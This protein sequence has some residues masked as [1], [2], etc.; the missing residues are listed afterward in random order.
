MWYSKSTVGFGSRW[1][2]EI[3]ISSIKRMFGEGVM[4]LKWSN[5]GCFLIRQN[6]CK[7]LGCHVD[8]ACK[9]AKIQKNI[10][11]ESGRWD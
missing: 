4:A 3:V 10:Q 2:V 7:P 5:G 8:Q 1:I 6:S 9:G 11:A